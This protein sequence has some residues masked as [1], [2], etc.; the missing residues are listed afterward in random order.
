MM[1]SSRDVSPVKGKMARGNAAKKD[2]DDDD[3]GKKNQVREFFFYSKLLGC[4]V[5][6]VKGAKKDKVQVAR[7]NVRLLAAGQQA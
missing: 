7:R 6:A 5:H 2:D 4:K 3:K 1:E